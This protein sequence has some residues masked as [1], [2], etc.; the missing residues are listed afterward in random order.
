MGQQLPLSGPSCPPAPTPIRRR[1]E[2]LAG[3]NV[4]FP[5]CDPRP[6]QAQ[7]LSKCLLHEY[8]DKFWLRKASF[9]GEFHKRELFLKLLLGMGEGASW[10]GRKVAVTHFR[11]RRS[12][13]HLEAPRWRSLPALPPRY[14]PLAS[15]VCFVGR[16]LQT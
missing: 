13:L 1:S 4:S 14:Q 16:G 15:G 12:H 11:R 3:L 5:D 6:G 2:A 8:V 9:A 7:W 10:A